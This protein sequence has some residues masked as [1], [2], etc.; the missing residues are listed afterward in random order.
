MWPAFDTAGMLAVATDDDGEFKVDFRRPVNL[1]GNNSLSNDYEIEY[2]SKDR[3][4][5][6]GDT[7]TIS[8]AADPLDDGDYRVR[9]APDI[10]APGNAADGTFRC[11]L[12]TKIA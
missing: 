6:Q 7:L 2:Q 10:N 12:L 1:V 5:V 11:A 8:G 4:L 3:T 9:Q